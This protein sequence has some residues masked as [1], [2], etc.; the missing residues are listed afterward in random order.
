MSPCHRGKCQSNPGVPSHFRALRQRMCSMKITVYE[1]K[2]QFFTVVWEAKSEF[3]LGLLFCCAFYFCRVLSSIK[4]VLF[5]LCN[6]CA[7]HNRHREVFHKSREVFY[8]FYEKCLQEVLS[9]FNA[10]LFTMTKYFCPVL[11]CNDG[12]YFQTNP[13]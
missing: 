13:K 7:R 5:E 8:K 2:S 10:L 9:F 3:L 4:N 6:I 1:K 12:D 11:G